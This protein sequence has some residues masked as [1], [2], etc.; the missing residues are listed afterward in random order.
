MVALLAWRIFASVNTDLSRMRIRVGDR[1]RDMAGAEGVVIWT[2]GD[3]DGLLW[4]ATCD[5]DEGGTVT[6]TMGE[7][8][9]IHRVKLSAT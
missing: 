4:W 8:E 7:F 1:V 6:K 5:M 9:K 3:N 2:E